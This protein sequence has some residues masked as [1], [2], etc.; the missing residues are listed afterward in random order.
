VFTLWTLEHAFDTFDTMGYRGKPLEREEARRLRATG[1]TMP[2]IAAELGVSRSSVSLWTQGVA[3]EPS[4]RT[5]ARRRGPNALQRRKQA[6]IEELLDEGR[7]RIGALS[8]REF[9]VAGAALYAGEGAKTGG[10]ARF[11]NTD[12]RM[13]AFFVAWLRRFYAIDESRLRVRVYLHDGLDLDAAVDFWSATLG[14]PISQFGA[15]YR[16]A[17]DP[18]RRHNKHEYGCAY[19][20]YSCSR[21]LRSILGLVAA[22]L[23]SSGRSPG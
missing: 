9:L 10:A 19:V 12:P 14:V 13:M 1:M 5:R 18:T 23:S 21:T 6:E 17:A 16:A 2:D 20:S 15:P 4:P 8:E 3:F 22:L 7:R 11:A